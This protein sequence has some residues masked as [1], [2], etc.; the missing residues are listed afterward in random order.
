MIVD[1][2]PTRYKAPHRRVYLQLE[3]DFL[4]FDEF[5]AR[6]LIKDEKECLCSMVEYLNNIKPQLVDGSHIGSNKITYLRYAFLG[7]K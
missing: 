6:H 2:Q 5:L 4:N 7:K 3:V 1:R